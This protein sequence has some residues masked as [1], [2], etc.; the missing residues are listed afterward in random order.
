MATIDI[1]AWPIYQI[2]GLYDNSVR[3]QSFA[4]LCDMPLMG[5]LNP[6]GVAEA[7]T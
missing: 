6:G 1:R 7:A 3:P 2:T 4:E 5:E